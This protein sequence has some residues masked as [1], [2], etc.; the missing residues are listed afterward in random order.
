MLFRCQENTIYNTTINT[1]INITIN[2][3]KILNGKI[4]DVDI[5]PGNYP[6]HY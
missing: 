4:F 2:T 3:D 1:A 5:L 6:A